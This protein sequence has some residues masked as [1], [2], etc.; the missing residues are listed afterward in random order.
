M[1]F[2]SN[3]SIDWRCPAT[4]KVFFGPSCLHVLHGT[5]CPLL[6]AFF[7]LSSL[8][9]TFHTILRWCWWGTEQRVAQTRVRG[10]RSAPAEISIVNS[11]GYWILM[12]M[13]KASL[14][15]KVLLKKRTF[16]KKIG[17]VCV[18]KSLTRKEN[19]SQKCKR[20][21]KWFSIFENH[22]PFRYALLRVIFVTAQPQP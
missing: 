16:P 7:Y 10:P 22:F 18:W 13:T 12:A 21:R 15:F 9:G 5:K 3:L 17:K 14:F 2:S 6:M 4:K 19:F 8:W 11:H 1:L 20:K